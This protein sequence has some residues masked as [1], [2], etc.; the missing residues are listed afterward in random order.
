MFDRENN[1]FFK[2]LTLEHEIVEIITPKMRSK[3]II[4]VVKIMKN[5]KYVFS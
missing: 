5:T 3:I 1:V 2:F 4:N